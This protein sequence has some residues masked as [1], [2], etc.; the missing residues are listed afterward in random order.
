VL[1]GGAAIL[2]ALPKLV[3]VIEAQDVAVGA[4]DPRE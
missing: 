3:A 1:F 4:V 2:T